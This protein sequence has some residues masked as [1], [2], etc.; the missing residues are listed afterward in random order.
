LKLYVKGLLGRPGMRRGYNIRRN[1]KKVACE[2]DLI[3]E[4]AED[5]AQRWA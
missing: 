4:L 5:R 3:I 2:D 1:H